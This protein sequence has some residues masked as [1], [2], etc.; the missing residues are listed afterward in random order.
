MARRRRAGGP[1]WSIEIFAPPPR[2]RTFLLNFLRIF[3]L[4]PLL[5]GLLTQFGNVHASALDAHVAR[6][7]VDEFLRDEADLLSAREEAQL[8]QRCQ[9]LYADLGV[10]MFL[11]TLPQ[12]GGSDDTPLAPA[13][14]ARQI[15]ADWSVE[16]PLLQGPVWGRGI[17]VLILPDSRQARIEFGKQ[18]AGEHDAIARQITDERLFPSLRGG[19]PARAIDLTFVALDAV[20]R[21]QPLPPRRVALAS[22]VAWSVLTLTALFTT[23]SLIRRGQTG[24][25]ARGWCRLLSM[26][27]GLLDRLTPAPTLPDPVICTAR[28]STPHCFAP[29]DQ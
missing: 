25:A 11:L 29:L 16:H 19:N 20:A 18:W 24:F 8:R 13:G 9:Q 22:I 6:P 27:G 26:P 12:G 21:Q 1:L 10:P 17:L 14:I 28:G 23:V 4:F 7:T 15:L 2:Y 5:L 3:W